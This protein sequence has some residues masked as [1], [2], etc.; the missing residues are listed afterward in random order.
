VFDLTVE[1][2]GT[3]LEGFTLKNGSCSLSSRLDAFGGGVAGGVL[4]DCKIVGCCAYLGGGA[5]HSNLTR[6]EIRSC[7]AD[8]YDEFQHENMH[9][10][11]GGG[12]YD[13]ELDNC[14]VH[15]CSADGDAGGLIYCDVYSCSIVDNDLYSYSM[16]RVNEID[17]PNY[18]G[19]VAGVN[20][21]NVSNSIVWGNVEYVEL[22]DENYN[23]LFDQYGNIQTS[24]RLNNC[25]FIGDN[26]KDAKGFFVDNCTYPTPSHW[27]S[28]YNPIIENNITTDPQFVD[29]TNGNYRLLSTSPCI[30]AAGWAATNAVMDLDGNTRVS[31]IAPDIGAYEYQYAAEPIPELAANATPVEVAAALSGSA[32]DSLVANVTNAAQYIA[33]REWALSVKNT[34]GVSGAG[35]LMVKDS[36]RAWLSFALG[37]DRLVPDVL[38]SDD[39]K[40]VSFEPMTEKGKFAFEVSIANVGIGEGV[41][42]T[43]VNREAIIG[44]MSKVLGIEGAAALEEGEFSPDNIIITFDVPSEGRARFIVTPPT[45]A[46]NSF[47][48]RIKMK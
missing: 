19:V 28:S 1:S 45:D 33:Y 15:W 16:V 34:N 13:C 3:M 40:I 12:A 42:I 5:F 14:I 18:G 9:E 29:A 30:D 7:W 39:I 17:M 48:M 37:A 26:D 21:C 2:F 35:A 11:M 43:D 8:S 27:L 31:G 44:N 10:G 38:T 41:T 22:Y 25:Y 46:G 23:P 32:D 47:F 36:P 20:F 6:C 24:K 4:F